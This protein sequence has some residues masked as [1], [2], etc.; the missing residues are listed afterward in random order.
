MA[1]SLSALPP[2]EALDFFRKKGFAIG[3]DWRDVW[4]E[5]Q[6]RAFTVAKAVR[7]DILEDIRQAVDKALAEGQT[8]SQFKAELTPKLKAKGWWGK[9]PIY[10]GK[11][12]R[13]V[14]S[15]LG[16]SRRLS[17]IY[18]TNLRMARA[19][20]QWQRIER[21]KARRPFLRYV[22]VLDGRTRPNHRD[23]NAFIFPVDHPFWNEWYPP[24][25]WRCRCTV[26]QLSQRDLD[27][28]D[29]KVTPDKDIAKIPKNEFIN[30]RSGEV[31]LIPSGISPGFNYNVGKAHMRGITPPPSTGPIRTPALVTG[32]APPMPAAR[33][34]DKSRL[35]DP[36]GKSD[37]QLVNIFLKEFGDEKHMAVTDKL[38]EAIM[39]GPDFFV[40]RVTGRQKIVQSIRKKALL[41]MADTLKDPDEIWWLW[42]FNKKQN[43]WKMRRRYF[44]RF[45]IDGEEIPVMIA[46]EVSPDGWK[47]VTAFRPTRMDY[48]MRQR[49]GVLAYRRDKK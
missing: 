23:K 47:G 6:A 15:Q 33:K 38:G 11:T 40:D 30:P 46:M 27:R 10:D 19:A 9:G 32:K 14:M 17:I 21:V 16:S 43:V 49:G 18:D 28:K 48:L 12:D 37:E 29:W 24:N 45:D 20:G 35:V 26:S 44:A 34:V 42:E 3:F 5:E 7:Y 13:L 41:L 25:G 36:K 1:F 31:E 22:A 4:K 8:L 2:T 39:I